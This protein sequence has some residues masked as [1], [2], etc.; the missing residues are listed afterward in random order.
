[1]DLKTSGAFAFGLIIGWYVYYV[2]RYRK[3]DVQISDITTVIGTIGGAAVLKLF[4]TGSDLFGAYGLG[5][6]T[7]FFLYFLV[8]VI[9]VAMSDNFNADWFLDGRRRNPAADSG[10][11]QDA[12]GPGTAMT[13]A[14]ASFHGQN[15]G[16]V[17][18][19]YLTPAE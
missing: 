18:N 6:A 17:Q 19:F 14:P 10:Y 1:M 4:D 13:L 5:L 2:N 15:P 3:G 16:T 7:G 11:G 8:L 12:R 9:L